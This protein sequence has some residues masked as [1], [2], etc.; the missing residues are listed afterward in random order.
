MGRGWVTATVGGLTVAMAL[1]LWNDGAR[2][3]G[4]GGDTPRF[5]VL[6]A[7]KVNLRAGPGDRYPI[8][9][10]FVR[11]DWPVEILGQ[12]DHWRHIRDWQGTEGWVHEKMIAARREVVVTGQIRAIRQAPDLA[13]P[14]VARAE[15]GVVAQLLEC[16]TGWCRI[17]AGDINGWIARTDIWGVDPNETLP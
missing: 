3:L 7:D 15:P 9:W 11:R 2:A 16:R 12:L 4:S 5:A 6:H 1:S 8:E 14:L 13:A 17:G 10:I